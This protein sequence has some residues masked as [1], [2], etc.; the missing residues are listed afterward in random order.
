MYVDTRDTLTLSVSRQILVT[1]CCRFLIFALSV[2]GKARLCAGA[3]V[4]G[5]TA[6]GRT[7]LHIAAA[8][9]KM[10]VLAAL[11]EHGKH[12]S[13]LGNIFASNQRFTYLWNKAN[14]VSTV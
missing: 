11:L 6:N 4:N 8:A 10:N 13:I 5:K 12:F 14:I 1:G 9:G 3:N 2:D 7:P